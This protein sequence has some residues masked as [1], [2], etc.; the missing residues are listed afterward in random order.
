LW[1][2]SE[3][4]VWYGDEKTAKG[5]GMM[6]RKRWKTMIWWSERDQMEWHH[7]QITTK[8]TVL[9]FENEKKEYNGDQ[10]AT[11]WNDLIIRKQYKSIVWW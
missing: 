10:K 3:E 1:S 4:M 6:I 7:D 5:N 9:W 2:E 8:G 11:K